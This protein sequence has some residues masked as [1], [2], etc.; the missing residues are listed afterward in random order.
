MRTSLFSAALLLFVAACDPFAA[1]QKADTIE[2]YEEFIENNP[3]SPW[4]LQAESRLEM[5]YLEKARSEG[6]LEAYDDFLARY[7][8]TT[9]RDEVLDEREGFLW[10]WAAGLNTEESYARFLEEYGASTK[11]GEAERRVRLLKYSSMV[12]MDELSVRRVNLAE[13]PD[14]EPNGWEIS[15]VVTNTGDVAIT[16]LVLDGTDEDHDLSEAW[17]VAAARWT[18]PIP[19]EVRAPLAPGEKRTWATTSGG[20]PAD[21]DGDFTLTIADIAVAR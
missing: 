11:R 1:A 12:T 20:P 2:A 16:T 15:A 9:L 17:P 14:A 21:W 13:I 6:T 10:D 4:K 5:L 8:R 3:T 19:D 7:P 18:M